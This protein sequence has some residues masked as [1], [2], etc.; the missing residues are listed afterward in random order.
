MA[1]FK[2]STDVSRYR[3][4]A[5][6][7]AFGFDALT[8]PNDDTPGADSLIVDAGAFLIAT[9]AFS[10]GAYLNA[11]KAWTLT[12]NGSIISDQASGII[13]EAG[14][15]TASSM[16]VGV[17]GSVVGT[18]A[19]DVQNGVT[20]KNAGYI[21][22]TNTAIR[23]D[24]SDAHT[25]TNAKGANIYGIGDAIVAIAGQSND[26][27]TNAG[28]I[29]GSVSL[30]DGND[31]F[32]NSGTQFSGSLE[33]GAGND[34]VTN[35]GQ[36]SSADLGDGNNILTNSGNMAAIDA[37]GGDDKVTN[38]G[39]VQNDV[40]LGDGHNTV[41]NSGDLQQ[42]VVLGAGNDTV[43]NSGEIQAF[44]AGAN[45]A[46][47]L[48]EGINKLTNSGTIGGDVSISGSAAGADSVSNTGLILG[49]IGLGGGLN[50]LANSGKGVIE[51]QITFG[52]MD[53]IVTNSGTISWNAGSAIDFGDGN[54]KLTNS[55]TIANVT[56]GAGDDIVNNT[57]TIGFVDLGAGNDKY[58]G[59]A[60]VDIVGDYNGADTIKLGGG[61]DFYLATGA[62]AGLDGND[63]I[64]GGAGSDTY[65]AGGANAV[66]I[67]LDSKD[68]SVAAFSFGV[69]AKS[70][71][72]G[73]A[74]GFDK[75]TGFENATGSNAADTI[76]G[77]GGANALSGGGNV[78]TLVG[79]AGN[80][81]LNGEDGG[82][83]LYGGMGRDIFNGGSGIDFFLYADVKESGLTNTTR[84]YI[85]DFTSSDF[86][87]LSA[88]DA[89]TKNGPGD[90]Q[91]NFIGTNKTFSG[92]A[93]ELRAYWTADGQI[94]EGD[95]NG[96]AKADFSIAIRDPLQNLTLTG[97][98]FIL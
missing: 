27:V 38:T 30:G 55:G 40:G 63:I 33:L 15:P 31:T 67:N 93:G 47:D 11:T 32:I 46:V 88:I 4:A 53:D 81:I 6:D 87:S 18:F 52:A 29:T 82:D 20:I 25:I 34:S 65:S 39:L 57:G 45:P 3:T 10:V 94:I 60:K 59:G 62:Q 78:D 8:D 9:G 72:S 56:F 5:A 61:T 54:N 79:F 89:N 22:G 36:M 35:S 68:Q 71:A 92:V 7:A 37:E 64:D 51:G 69:I 42:R 77:N 12:V 73:S 16:T 66:L 26:K 85:E 91:F 24:G 80:D 41:T 75:I 95:V 58:T 83:L 97:A 49:S 28:F 84:D 1:T 76:Y 14:L 98:D 50:T 44:L 96:D 17:E 43:A 23:L 2:I 70:S 48:D 90:D 74:V 21:L 13:L 86:I 19:M